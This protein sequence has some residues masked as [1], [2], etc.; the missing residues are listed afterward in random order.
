MLTQLP[1]P[2][3]DVSLGAANYAN[4]F[5]FQRGIR[6]KRGC[7]NNNAQSTSYSKNVNVLQAWCRLIYCLQRYSH[8]LVM[9][10]TVKDVQKNIYLKLD[11]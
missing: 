6:A 7:M 5:T 10:A 11:P 3:A 9:C 2:A 8:E 4:Y 1:P